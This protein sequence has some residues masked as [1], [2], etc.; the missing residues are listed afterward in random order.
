M[1]TKKAYYYWKATHRKAT[2][3]VLAACLMAASALIV[4]CSD[5][6]PAGP[7]PVPK[8]NSISSTTVSPGD[9]VT[10]SGADFATPAPDNRVYFNNPVE[11]A[12]P[13]SGGATRLTVVVPDNAATGTIRVTVPD[14]PAAGV[15]PHVSADRRRGGVEG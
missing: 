11:Y 14:Q 13:Y 3:G 4:A 15:G 9:T 12:R 2:S 5:D 6:E 8:V 10:I 7:P 1:H